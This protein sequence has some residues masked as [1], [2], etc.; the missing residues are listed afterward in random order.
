MKT[1]QINLFLQNFKLVASLIGR[2][3]SIPMYKNMELMKEH[4]SAIEKIQT[5]SPEFL[6]LRGLITAKYA[7]VA[8]KD[9]QGKPKKKVT[10]LADGRQQEEFIITIPSNQK[11]IDDY[12]ASLEKEHP[13]VFAEHTLKLKEYEKAMNEDC[14]IEFHMVNED[15]LPE[16]ISPQQVSMLSFMIKFK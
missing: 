5:P 6:E 12:V 9:P 14:G 16:D 4:T 1:Y 15:D 7:E 2:K 13:K 8:D 3:L 11:K 10:P